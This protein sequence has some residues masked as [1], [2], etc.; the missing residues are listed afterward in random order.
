MLKLTLAEYNA[1]TDGDVIYVNPANISHFKKHPNGTY[2]HGGSA[3]NGCGWVVKESA[4][5]VAAMMPV[6]QEEA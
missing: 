6:P 3:V 2:I 1:Q 4:E 5:E